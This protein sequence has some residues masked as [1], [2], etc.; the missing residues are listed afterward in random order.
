[1]GTLVKKTLF[2]LITIFVAGHIFA[3]KVMTFS[4]MS[5]YRNEIIVQYKT[6]LT[7]ADL[8]TLSNIIGIKIDDEKSAMHYIETYYKITRVIKKTQSTDFVVYKVADISAVEAIVNALKTNPA[9]VY[10][11]PNYMFS[12]LYTVVAT[13]PND[14]FYQDGF[15]QWGFNKIKAD[16]AY[17]AGLIDL[18][19]NKTIIVAVLDTGIYASHQDFV[20]KLVAGWNVIE[21]TSNPADDN[22][23]YHGTH[24]AGIIAANTNDQTVLGAGYP[25]MAGVAYTNAS[26]TAQVK[27]MPVKVLDYEG[28]GS[29]ADIATGIKWAVDNGANIINCSFGS[30][31]ESVTLENAI[32]YALAQGCI[33]VA[34][35]G[36]TSSYGNVYP[37]HYANVVSVGATDE[38]DLKADFSTWGKVDVVAPGTDIWSCSGDI[39]V[40]TALSGT[41]FSAP[42]A[43]GAL[44]MILLKNEAILPERAINILEQTA[45]DVDVLGR[46]SKTGWGR[47]NLYR[48]LTEEVS[49]VTGELRT[50][51]WPNPFS[52]A[53]NTYINITFKFPTISDTTIKIYDGGGELVWEK[54][55]AAGELI[56]GYNVAR[57]DGKNKEGRAVANGTYFLLVKN[58]INTGKTKIAIVY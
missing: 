37:A 52:P 26:W 24:V 41:S 6:P 53:K 30:D 22:D 14:S 43:T 47:V 34:S 36:N 40:Y 33:C 4:G 16:M 15:T 28:L 49:L 1:M 29:V 48:A 9:V 50:Y 39:A 5:A 56:E 10:A 27:V 20:G 42:Y 2:M 54:T 3:A 12:A 11:E 7:T 18:S 38:N 13:I 35:S 58:K 45:D 32:N 44:A 8:G 17:N 55:L 25:S 23:I 51:V 57:W 31:S 21:G 19:K 46:D